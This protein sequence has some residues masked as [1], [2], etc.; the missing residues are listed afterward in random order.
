MAVRETTSGLLGELSFQFVYG[1]KRATEEHIKP[2]RLSKIMAKKNV[3]FFYLFI[4]LKKAKLIRYF[5]DS[6]QF[7]NFAFS[8]LTT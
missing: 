2:K 8:N 3:C 1:F 7:V 5:V 4:F 6:G